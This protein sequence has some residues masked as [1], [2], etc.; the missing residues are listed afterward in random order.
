MAAQSDM[1]EIESS[2]IALEKAQEDGVRAFAQ[3]MVDDHTASSEAM[4]QAAEADGVNDIPTTPDDAH[5]QMISQLQ[6]ASADQFDSAYMQM[7]LQ[8]HQQAVALF[9]GYAEQEG[10]LGDFAETTLPKLQEHL[11]HAHQLTQ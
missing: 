7:Q 1:F 6:E 5:Q 8:A 4:K 3:Q 2:R 11:Q 10:A 9:E